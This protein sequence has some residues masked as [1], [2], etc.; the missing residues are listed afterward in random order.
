MLCHPAR[1]FPDREPVD[2]ELAERVDPVIA[3]AVF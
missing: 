3:Y 1:G 2:E